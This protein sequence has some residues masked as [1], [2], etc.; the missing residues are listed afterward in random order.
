LTQAQNF[1]L[2]GGSVSAI[3]IARELGPHANRIYQSQRNG[4]FDLPASMLPENAYR[5]EEV[6]SYDIPTP[7]RSFALQHDEAIPATVTLTSGRKICDIHQVILCTGYHLTLPFLPHMHSDDTPVDNA[8]ETVLVTDGSQF[9]NLHKDIFYIPDPTL[10]FIGVPFLTATFTLFE[11]QAMAAAKVLSG[12]AMLPSTR[13]MR[14]EYEYRVRSKGYG[15]AFHSLHNGEVEY[16]DELMAWVNC[17]LERAGRKTLGRH[18]Q[19]WH[20]AKEQQ[21]QQIKAL[22]AKPSIERSVEVTCL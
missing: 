22:F 9:H 14:V 7:D 4:K 16:V 15:K 10:I 6:V 18:T 2:V 8:N 21:A 5:I 3:D 1:L 20:A 12:Q 11:F 17:D 13:D 19:R